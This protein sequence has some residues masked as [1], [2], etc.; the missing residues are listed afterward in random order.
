MNEKPISLR[1]FARQIG[2]GEKTV[3]DGIRLGK[4]SKGVIHD[5]NRPKILY[6][7]A[8][9][10]VEAFNLGYRA[11]LVKGEVTPVKGSKE[12][13]PTPP[14]EEGQYIAGL[15][16]ETPLATAQRAEKIFKAQL[17]SL[18]VS[19]KVGTLVSKA[20]A[21]KQLFKFGGEI[22]A[23]LL[24]LP[25]RIADDLISLAPDRNAVY[26]LLTDSLIEAL[27]ALSELKGDED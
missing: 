7:E 4:I 20:E 27:E 11:K 13:P 21:D 25:D 18:E 17:A 24:A 12:D 8:I 3:R 9:K 15:G 22:R 2:V 10:E 5:G 19:E 16:P 14:E 26:S 1:E 6:S 23:R